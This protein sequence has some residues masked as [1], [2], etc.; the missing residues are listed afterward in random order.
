MIEEIFKR[1]LEA[2]NRGELQEAERLY[3]ECLHVQESPEAWNN[4]GNVYVRME[5]Y[6]EA[7]ECYR[8]AIECDPSFPTAYINLASLF[9]NLERFAEAKLLLMSLIEKGFKNDQTLAML[10]VCDLALNDLAGAVR[11]YKGNASEGL[12]RELADYGVLERLR[13]LL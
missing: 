9:L 1:A 13:Q 3:K 4:L 7:M 10:I 2:S 8:K 12:D 6:A 11:L 5:K